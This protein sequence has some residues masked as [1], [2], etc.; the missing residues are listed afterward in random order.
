MNADFSRGLVGRGGARPSR[1]SAILPPRTA[2][3]TTLLVSQRFADEIARE[4]A[5]HDV[6]AEL[7]NFCAE[8]IFNRLIRILDEA[9]F[10][11]ANR[12]VKLVEFPIDNLIHNTCRL[13]FH[14]GFINLAL[15]LDQ[16]SG[17]VFAANVTR[18]SRGNVKRDIFHKRA[19]DFILRH[20]VG[21]AVYFDEHTHF[22]LKMNVRSNDAL[23]RNA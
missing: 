9:L 18:M 4:T 22:A 8:Q 23:F 15:S 1:N 20:E 5:D 2:A 14:L 13:A 19:E 12:A 17:Y 11:Q 3:A 6:L 21:L 10:E 16:F 7:G